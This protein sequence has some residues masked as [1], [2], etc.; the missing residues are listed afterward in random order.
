MNL[1]AGAKR[2][3]IGPIHQARGGTPKLVGK[4]T[5]PTS[6]KG[7]ADMLVIEHAVFK[8]SENGTELV[9]QLSNLSTKELIEITGAPF[10]CNS[11]MFLSTEK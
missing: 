2:I 10:Q 6:G 11:K 1:V 3:I 9:E 8:F 4:L 7:R 5:F